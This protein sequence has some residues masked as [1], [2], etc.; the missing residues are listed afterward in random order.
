MT[1]TRRH[2]PTTR[3]QR[4]AS[5]AVEPMEKRLTLSPAL[6]RPTPVVASLVAIYP[7]GPLIPTG[8]CIPSGPCVPVGPSQSQV[9]TSYPN[10]PI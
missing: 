4:S 3:R 10:A 2:R 6:A 1:L 9:S 8:P 5:I 7:N